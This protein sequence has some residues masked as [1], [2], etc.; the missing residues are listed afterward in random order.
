MISLF[1]GE[2]RSAKRD[3]IGDP[4]QV[5]DRHIDFAAIAA[6]IDAKLTLG[7]RGK[8]GR[9]PYPTETMVRLLLGTHATHSKVETFATTRLVCRFDEPPTYETDSEWNRARSAELV[10]ETRPRAL[11]VLVPPA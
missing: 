11:S 1:A 8:G 9:P 5:L 3:R 4:L 6:A 7:D 2:D 10:I